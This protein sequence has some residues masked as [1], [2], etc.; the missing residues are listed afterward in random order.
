MFAAAESCVSGSVWLRLIS[1]SH[2]VQASLAAELLEAVKMRSSVAGIAEVMLGFQSQLPTYVEFM[3]GQYEA[4]QLLNSIE[5]KVCMHAR[6][7]SAIIVVAS[8]H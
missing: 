7:A 3:N 5:S 6:A 4:E 2:C 8:P 1:C